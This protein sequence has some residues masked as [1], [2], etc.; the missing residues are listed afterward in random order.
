MKSWIA[1]FNVTALMLSSRVWAD[2]DHGAHAP[3]IAAPFWVWAVG[4]GALTLIVLILIR[5]ARRGTLINERF[6]GFSRNARLLLIRSPFSG[7]S[8]SLIRLLF[9]I[10]L[11][12]VGFDMLFVADRKS[13][14]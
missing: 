7:L 9:N 1:I 5:Q 4:L 6:R 8:S 3:K 13:T 10:Y 2:G 11:L 12:A 14:R